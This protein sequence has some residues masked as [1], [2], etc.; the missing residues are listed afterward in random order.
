MI[1]Q[2]PNYSRI[3]HEREKKKKKEKAKQA[4][5]KFEAKGETVG[6][7]AFATIVVVMFLGVIAALPTLGV[8]FMLALL[9]IPFIIIYFY[10]IKRHKLNKKAKNL[11][12]ICNHCGGLFVGRKN[13]CPHCGEKVKCRLVEYKCDNCGYKFMGR[14][15]EC[16]RCSVGLWYR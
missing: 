13:I 6:S 14:K 4:G 9:S 5:A 12:Y 2:G 7:G 3:N 10:G 8:S 15:E 1:P 16:P 11:K